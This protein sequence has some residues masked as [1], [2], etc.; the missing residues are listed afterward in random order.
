MCVVLIRHTDTIKFTNSLESQ[1]VA[2]V[3]EPI[4]IKTKEYF[5]WLT[6][7]KK[8]SAPFENVQSEHI[9]C[10]VT[11]GGDGRPTTHPS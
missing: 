5:I 10:Y 6:L 3:E 4:S 1:I 11:L 2:R 9:S 8:V 7:V